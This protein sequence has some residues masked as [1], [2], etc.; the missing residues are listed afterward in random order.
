[1]SFKEEEIGREDAKLDVGIKR[2]TERPTDR[3]RGEN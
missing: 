1:M 2:E 3:P